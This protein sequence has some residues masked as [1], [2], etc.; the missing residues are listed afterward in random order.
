MEAVDQLTTYIVGLCSLCALIL[1]TVR[2]P[3]TPDENS[4]RL[5]KIIYRVYKIAEFCNAV[6]DS[7]K[8]RPDESKALVEISLRLKDGGL[9]P[10]TASVEV[11]RIA[12]VLIAR[13]RKNVV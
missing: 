11:E 5:D 7:V 9:D 8:Q 6:R 10:V 2:T 3:T 1:N 4:S 13:N 12:A